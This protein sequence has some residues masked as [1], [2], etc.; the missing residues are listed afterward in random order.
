VLTYTALEPR[1]LDSTVRRSFFQIAF[2]FSA[3]YLLLIL[4]T[5]AIQPFTQTGPLQLMRLSNLWLGPVQGLV[6]SAIGVLF[7]SK[8]D[9]A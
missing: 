6:A 9:H 7:V 5:L 2:G 8:K 3:F 1:L 4:L